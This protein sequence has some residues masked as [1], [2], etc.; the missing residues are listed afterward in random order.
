MLHG[1]TAAPSPH[2]WVAPAA[3]CAPC[4]GLSLPALEVPH[5]LVKL[6]YC[7]DCVAQVVPCLL[8][9]SAKRFPVDCNVP[10]FGELSLP[11]GR[12]LTGAVLY[13]LAVHWRVFP[14]LYSLPIWICLG[15]SRTAEQQST[16]ESLISAQEAGA[17][18]HC[19]PSENMPAQCEQ[20]NRRP[21]C[22]HVWVHAA[23]CSNLT[24]LLSFSRAQ[25]QFAATSLTTFLGLAAICYHLYGQPFL[26]EAYLYHSTRKDPRHN[27]SV[28]FYH[29]YLQ[30]GLPPEQ[31]TDLTWWAHIIC[32]RTA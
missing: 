32:P 31:Q 19:M 27:F 4:M 15:H 25:L 9:V 29:I 6:A 30:T 3:V 1:R 23:G 14:V 22:S 21:D 8:R 20:V 5:T 13:G 18:L 17:Q 28:W 2:H 7:T 12:H 24:L 10:R 26:E 11:A 16:S